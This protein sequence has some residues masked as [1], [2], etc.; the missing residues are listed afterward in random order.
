MATVFARLAA[1]SAVAL[2]AVG[3]VAAAQQ[4]ETGSALRSPAAFASMGDERARSLALFQEASK[5]ITHPRCMNCHPASDTPNQ[6][7]TMK[8]HRPPVARGLDGHGLVVMR[9]TTCHGQAN[10]DPARVPGH[11]N[12]HLAPVSMAW[13]GLSV[14]QI[15]RQLKDRDRNG[16]LDMAALLHHMAE[17]SLV[18]WAW[19][20]GKGRTP[21]PGSQ[22]E[23]GALVKAWADTGAHCPS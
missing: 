9:C 2:M 17:D 22:A 19:S 7:D 3:A 1:V 20:P 4:A 10:Y 15:C 11:P 8:P 12:W 18:G 23:F 16:G 14:G 5:V 6:G 21:A 13:E